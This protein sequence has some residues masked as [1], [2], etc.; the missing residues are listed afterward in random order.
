M[1]EIT[2]VSTNIIVDSKQ[3]NFEEFVKNITWRE[4]LI[5]LV[6]TNKINPWD[7]NI[8]KVVDNYIDTVKKMQTLDLHVPAN[9]ILAASILLYMKS[10]SLKLFNEPEQ[11]EEEQ[12][13]QRVIPAVP[14][15]INKVRI[16]PNRRITLFELMAALDEAMKIKDNKE[17]ITKENLI[18]LVIELNKEDIDNKIN[19]IMKIIDQNYDKEKMITFKE[20]SNHFIK[21][22]NNKNILIDLFI[23]LLFL[24]H[25]SKI[26]IIQEIFFGEII[27]TK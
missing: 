12:E 9:I 15:L 20:L 5:E 22:S 6:E 24:A 23:P 1:K 11:I 2:N 8:S 3:I 21:L 16:Q 4:L 14:Q 7:I 10:T 13:A 25:Q 26:T 18:P 17:I 27:I 19:Q